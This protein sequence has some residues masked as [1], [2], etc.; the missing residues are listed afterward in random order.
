M[1]SFDEMR[2]IFDRTRIL[3]RPTHGIIS[4]YHELP[5]ICLG[6]TG[7]M[8]D[9]T[10]EVRGKIQVS[11]RFVLR[12]QHLEPQ[13]REIFGEDNVDA[14]L[15]GRVFGFMGFRG[16]PVECKSAHLTVQR[17]HEHP[18]KVLDR[19]LDGLEREEDITTSVI[20]TPSSRYYPVSIE[21]FLATILEDEFN[22]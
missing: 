10:L 1:L 16:R 6:M 13:Y 5:Y 22:A 18:E 17:L 15:T 4:G 8:E 21:R 11:P 2:E 3:R 12:P 20:L 7:E 9:E 19:V 14:E